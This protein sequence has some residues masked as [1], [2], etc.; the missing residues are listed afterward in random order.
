MIWY[1]H[2]LSKEIYLCTAIKTNKQ[3][4]R[5]KSP[6]TVFMLAY[7]VFAATKIYI[8]LTFNRNATK[9]N[10]QLQTKTVPHVIRFFCMKFCYQYLLCFFYIKKKTVCNHTTT[11]EVAHWILAKK[12]KKQNGHTKYTESQYTTLSSH[13]TAKRKREPTVVL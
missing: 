5:I 8:Y 3:V 4:N 11:A 12:K 13:L 2:K 7:I 1:K 6:L 10:S 9:I